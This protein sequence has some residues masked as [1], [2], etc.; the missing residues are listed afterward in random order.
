MKTILAATLFI[1]TMLGHSAYAG[2]QVDFLFSNESARVTESHSA[3]V[4][5]PV[6][7][8]LNA[9]HWKWDQVD[10]Q[11]AIKQVFPQGRTVIEPIEVVGA[12]SRGESEL[13]EVDLREAVSESRRPLLGDI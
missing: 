13:S 9:V 8:P 10:A 5:T 2:P 3:L 7:R 11:E 12:D 1:F 4:A 6:E